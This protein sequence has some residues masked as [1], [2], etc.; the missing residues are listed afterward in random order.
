MWPTVSQRIFLPLGSRAEVPLYTK[1]LSCSLEHQ[2]VKATVIR[3][4]IWS[5]TPLEDTYTLSDVVVDSLVMIDLASRGIEYSNHGNSSCTKHTVV[6]LI[7][8]DKECPIHD[9][10]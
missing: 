9:S 2:P 6:M 4:H 3:Q 8:I 7:P 10:L 1:S 5:V